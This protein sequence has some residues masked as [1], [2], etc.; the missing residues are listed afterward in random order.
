LSQ[1]LALVLRAALVLVLVRLLL[2]FVAG[3]VRGY[4]GP[5]AGRPAAGGGAGELVRDRVCNT[6][7]P[8]ARALQAVVAGEGQY[9]CSAACRDKAVL[10]ARRAS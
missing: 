3:V 5:D 4:R 7:V 8:K 9:F 6:F 2:R 10:A 1:L